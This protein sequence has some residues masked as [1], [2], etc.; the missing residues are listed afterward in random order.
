MGGFDDDYEEGCKVY[1][2]N[3][4]EGTSENDVRE[5]MEKAGEVDRVWIARNP[6]GFGY[7]TFYNAKDAQ[8]AIYKCD[9][10]SLEGRRIRVELAKRKSRASPGR[11]RRRSR[12]RSFSRRRSRSRSRRRSRSRSR[13]KRSRSRSR[14]SSSR[15]R[16]PKARYDPDRPRKVFIG[17]LHDRIEKEDLE[18]FFRRAGKIETIWV[19]RDPPGYGFVTFRDEEDARYAVKDLNGR[20]IMGNK[21]TVEMSHGKPGRAA[22]ARRSRRRSRS[23]SSRRR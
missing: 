12:S 3:L 21:V 9:G 16:S 10:K 7:V 19:A 17:N 20:L 13:R 2:G 1:V 18:D 8:D 4:E 22:L 14:R 15:S 6:P 23:Y 11:S 5:I